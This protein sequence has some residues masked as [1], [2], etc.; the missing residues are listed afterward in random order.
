M[1]KI[2]LGQKLSMKSRNKLKSNFSNFGKN[3]AVPVQ[4]CL[5][6]QDSISHFIDGWM[7]FILFIPAAIHRFSVANNKHMAIN[8]KKYSRRTV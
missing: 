4:P 5:F 1:S 8:S 3:T 7:E 2:I 6:I